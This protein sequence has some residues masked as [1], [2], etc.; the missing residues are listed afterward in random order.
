MNFKYDISQFNFCFIFEKWQFSNV[1]TVSL[2]LYKQ[3]HHGVY[4]KILMKSGFQIL[5]M[6]T[7]L[8]KEE[9][10]SPNFIGPLPNTPYQQLSVLNNYNHTLFAVLKDHFP[11]R[12]MKLSCVI[13]HQTLV[14]KSGEKAYKPWCYRST[15]R[16]Q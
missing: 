4:Q 1:L 9:R 15:T 12:L 6:M 3:L 8:F 5:I 16:S 13:L 10:V 11:T 2:K 14:S 7:G